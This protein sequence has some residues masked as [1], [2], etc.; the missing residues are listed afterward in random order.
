MTAWSFSTASGLP[1]PD[2]LAVI[3]HGHVLAG[4]RHLDDYGCNR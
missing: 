2:L 3:Q 1:S 4:I